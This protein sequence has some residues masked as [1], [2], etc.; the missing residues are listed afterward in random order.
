M[1]DKLSLVN[2]FI[3][4]KSEFLG[5]KTTE[6]RFTGFSISPKAGLVFAGHGIKRWAVRLARNIQQMLSA[7]IPFFLQKLRL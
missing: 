1:F 7:L 6:K 3:C 4:Q 5:G 2:Y